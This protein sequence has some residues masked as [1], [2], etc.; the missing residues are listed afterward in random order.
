MET[1]V[2]VPLMGIWQ[3]LDTFPV[4]T[5]RHRGLLASSR[6]RPRMLLNVV[7][8][9][10]LFPQQRIIQHETSTALRLRNSALDSRNTTVNEEQTETLLP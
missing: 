5:T 2:T 8:C 7:Q 4:V 10:E 3:G 6:Q 9:P 1:G